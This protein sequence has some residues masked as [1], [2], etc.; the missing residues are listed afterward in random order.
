MQQPQHLVTVV[1]LKT[2]TLRANRWCVVSSD[3]LVTEAFGPGSN[4]T[5]IAEEFDWYEASR[6]VGAD[7]AQNN[8]RLRFGDSGETQFVVHADRGRTDVK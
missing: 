8:E 5:S 4:D 7:G 3:F 6:V 1:H 2:V